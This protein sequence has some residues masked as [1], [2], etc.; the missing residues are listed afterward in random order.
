MV[1]AGRDLKDHVVSTPLPW[2]GNLLLDQVTE[3]LTFNTFRDGE[4][5]ASLG[6]ITAQVD[7]RLQISLSRHQMLFLLLH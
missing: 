3:S 4:S 6:K 7:T 1:W 5:T 2:V